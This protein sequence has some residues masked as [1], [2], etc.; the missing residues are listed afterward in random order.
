MSGINEDPLGSQEMLCHHNMGKYLWLGSSWSVIVLTILV[1][2]II[3]VVILL[4]KPPPQP[5]QPPEP[6][7]TPTP[8]PP[9]KNTLDSIIKHTTTLYNDTLEM[10]NP[11]INTKTSS[12]NAFS[13]TDLTTQPYC[14]ITSE[15]DILF[16]S[17]WET[18]GASSDGLYSFGNNGS[19]YRD[20]VSCVHGG[21]G[22]TKWVIDKKSGTSN[23]TCNKPF[24][25]CGC[26]RESHNI[27][28]LGVGQWSPE[29]FNYQQICTFP[30]DRLSF[31]LNDHPGSTDY[32]TEPE[33]VCTRICDNTDCCTGV[34]FKEY[35]VEEKEGNTGQKQ[36]ILLYDEL[37]IKSGEELTMESYI[38]SELFIKK[39]K[40]KY[41]KFKDR[42]F[43]Y[44]GN[45]PTR[46]WFSDY[47]TSDTGDTELQVLRQNLHI[48]LSFKPKYIINE[49]GCL[50][51]E[52]SCPLGKPF[53][54]IFSN[55]AIRDEDIKGILESGGTENTLIIYRNVNDIF[56]PEEWKNIFAITI[57]PDDYV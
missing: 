20:H 45:L 10:L 41:P 38:Q 8:T 42:V 24:Y 17:W 35:E 48:Q 53:V 55:N 40:T 7:P 56:I 22:N 12:P 28:Y 27:D 16:D 5:T 57:D 21:R 37:V 51:L 26:K 2:G 44:R 23:C 18:I 29:K 33:V 6:T 30:A 43:V 39:S 9:T 49:T 46:F 4:I 15:T 36:C 54:T 34:V 32:D 1:L 50:E 13:G 11:I 31:N 52:P 47:Y 14:T 19:F 3:L 25:G